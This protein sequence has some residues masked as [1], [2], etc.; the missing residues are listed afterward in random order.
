[1]L[2]LRKSNKK[3]V[4]KGGGSPTSLLEWGGVKKNGDRC[5][6]FVEVDDETKRF[7]QLQWGK[8]LVK[9]GGNLLGTMHFG[10]EFLLLCSPIV[11]GG[12]VAGFYS[13]ADE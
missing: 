8:I 6:G 4:G 13:G 12:A 1:M 10:G 2:A 11:V 9:T 5:G 7:S 3:S